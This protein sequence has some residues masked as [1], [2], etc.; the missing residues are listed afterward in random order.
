MK[1][2]HMFLVD[3]K[4]RDKKTYPMPENYRVNFE[5]PFTHVYSVEILDASIPRTQYSV[6]KH[7]NKLRINS[8]NGDD[9]NFVTLELPIGDY[10]DTNIITA[11]NDL[12]NQNNIDMLIRNVSSPAILQHTFE[13]V[14][15]SKFELDMHNSTINTVLGFDL[16]N[17]NTGQTPDKYQFVK[18]FNF[19]QDYID[20][21]ILDPLETEVHEN[22]WFGSL[23]TNDTITFIGYESPT[24]LGDTYSNTPMSIIQPFSLSSDMFYDSAYVDTLEVEIQYGSYTWSIKDS[25]NNIIVNMDKTVN[26]QLIKDDLIT[27]YLHLNFYES[28]DVNVADG[29]A[30]NAFIYDGT[31]QTLL[32]INDGINFEINFKLNMFKYL[33]K[34]IAPG[35]YSLLGER[36]L[37]LHCPEVEEHL[38]KFRAYENFTMGLAKFKLSV[39]GFEDERFDF[40]TTPPREFHPIGK[41]PSLTFQ[42]K[43]P[44]G[45][46][47]NFRGIN[48]TLTIIIRY[49]T[50]IQ[51][52]ESIRVF[53]SKLNPDYDPDIFRYMQDKG[54]NTD[55]DT[56]SDV[57]E[58]VKQTY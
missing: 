38:F 58:I 45:S 37:T 49:Y 1:E 8:Y 11:I 25:D 53:K 40:S 6:D 32:T 42:F 4:N 27:Y 20:N 19:T 39:Q 51:T 52:E 33:Y 30:N 2:S 31:T 10:N 17:I 12:F 9:V 14:S 57:D 3:S 23:Y 34:I 16:Y 46:F 22:R 55:S 18:N 36:Y 44:D 28:F 5:N 56:D 24:N 7:N 21:W 26:N 35:L 54:Y 50:P 29:S 43:N 47:Y 13:F 41:L 15:V 48:H